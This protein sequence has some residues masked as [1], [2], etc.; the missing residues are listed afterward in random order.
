[1]KYDIAYFIINYCD[2]DCNKMNKMKGDWPLHLR[3]FLYSSI[4]CLQ[5]SF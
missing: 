3:L 5:L 2:C 4:S 1:M